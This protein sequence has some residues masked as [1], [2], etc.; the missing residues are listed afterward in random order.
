MT[1]KTVSQPSPRL[2]ACYFFRSLSSPQQHAAATKTESHLRSET[3]RLQ[4]EATREREES[5]RYRKE[6]E[7]S[8]LNEAKQTGHQLTRIAKLESDTEKVRQ[9]LSSA[10]LMLSETKADRDRLRALWEGAVGIAGKVGSGKKSRT[11]RKKAS[12]AK[13]T[14]G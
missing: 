6:L 5:V 12:R 4:Q 9:K 3:H 1:R 8:R 2:L 10:E 14:E 11:G 13:T 7:R